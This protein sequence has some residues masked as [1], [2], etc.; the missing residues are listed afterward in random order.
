MPKKK[1]NHSRDA[2][3]DYIRQTAFHIKSDIDEMSWLVTS[4]RS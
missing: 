4:I 3:Q 2:S 1:K